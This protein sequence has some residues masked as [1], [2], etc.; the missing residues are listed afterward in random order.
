MKASISP[1]PVIIRSVYSVPAGITVISCAFENVPEFPEISGKSKGRLAGPDP[2]PQ[3][4]AAVKVQNAVTVF[5]IFMENSLLSEG[6]DNVY[7][8]NGSVFLT[9]IR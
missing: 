5:F 6:E 4:G 9:S 3:R 7:Y 8:Y 2:Q 1:L